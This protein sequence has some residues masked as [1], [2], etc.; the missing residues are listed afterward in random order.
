MIAVTLIAV[1]L[2]SAY[3]NYRWVKVAYSNKGVYNGLD[4]CLFDIART[5]I[6]VF[7][8]YCAIYGWAFD[9]PY[10][11]ED[12]PTNHQLFNF[13]RFFNIKNTNNDTRTK[14]A[15]KL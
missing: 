15:G 6:P 4:T 9:S 13:N 11:Y 1:Y 14:N 5:I 8:T 3:V 7:N 12:I 10:E 2:V